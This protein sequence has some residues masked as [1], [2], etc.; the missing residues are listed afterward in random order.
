MSPLQYC[1]KPRSKF[2]HLEG[3]LNNQFAMSGE[4]Q[5]RFDGI[6]TID[7]TGS[8]NVPLFTIKCEAGSFKDEFVGERPTKRSRVEIDVVFH[9]KVSAEVLS[10]KFKK[11]VV[12][13]SQIHIG[14]HL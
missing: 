12:K 14:R 11:M 5:C 7:V 8:P 2:K 13:R 6:D 10:M 3:N 9:S 4:F 1:L